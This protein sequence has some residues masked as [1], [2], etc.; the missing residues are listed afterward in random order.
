MQ[1]QFFYKSLHC[2]SLTKINP[3]TLMIVKVGD[4]HKM[5]KSQLMQSWVL[6]HLKHML[7]LLVFFFKQPLVVWSLIIIRNAKTSG[8]MKV[9]DFTCKIFH[10]NHYQSQQRGMLLT[11]IVV[12]FRVRL[13]Q[14]IYQGQCQRHKHGLKKEYNFLVTWIGGLFIPR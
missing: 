12:C 2:F 11:T 5:E 1:H 3:N 13:M 6:G 10:V 9:C 14:D 4:H 8:I 7:A